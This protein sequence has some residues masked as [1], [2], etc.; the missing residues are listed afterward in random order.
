MIE[1]RDLR[2]IEVCGVMEK[3]SSIIVVVLTHSLT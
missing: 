3:H 2:W 1:L